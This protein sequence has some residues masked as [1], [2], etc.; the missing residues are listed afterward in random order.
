MKKAFGVLLVVALLLSSSSLSKGTRSNTSYNARTSSS[1]TR[2]YCY[3]CARVKLRTKAGL[4][5]ARCGS[6]NPY[7]GSL[8][9]QSSLRIFVASLPAL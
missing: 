6:L 2:S 9:H 4:N 3:S 7:N 1:H 8:K 5:S